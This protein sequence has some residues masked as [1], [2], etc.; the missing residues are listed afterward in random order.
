MLVNF[1]PPPFFHHKVQDSSPCDWGWA[2]LS[3]EGVKNACGQHNRRRKDAL[4]LKPINN[5]HISCRNS[6]NDR[7]LTLL[8]WLR[9]L[10]LSPHVTLQQQKPGLQAV[11][12]AAAKDARD[13]EMLHTQHDKF[14]GKMRTAL[15]Q[16]M[17][18]ARCSLLLS[19]APSLLFDRLKMPE[20][21]P[22]RP[23][24][25]TSIDQVKCYNYG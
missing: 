20:L 14:F 17:F 8:Q 18:A 21:M 19:Q 7:C 5:G 13:L 1:V 2:S 12:S 22:L 24:F 10:C 6:C 15:H 16:K 23:L 3:T 25:T 11:L 4:L 9:R